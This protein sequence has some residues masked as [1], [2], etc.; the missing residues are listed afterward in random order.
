MSDTPAAKAEPAYQ[1]Y[2]FGGDNDLCLI[3][4]QATRARADEYARYL[5]RDRDRG[6]HQYVATPFGET[7]AD[8]TA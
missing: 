4:I 8:R 7:K 3:F 2:K 5:N 6:T 1:W